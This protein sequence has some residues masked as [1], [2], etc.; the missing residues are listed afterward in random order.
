MKT[1]FRTLLLA[2]TVFFTGCIQMLAVRAVGG[3][4]EEGMDT[5]YEESDLDLAREG[6]SGNLKLLEALI[7]ADPE[8]E[9]LLL[10]AAQGFSAYSLAFAEDDSLERAQALYLRSRNYALRAFKERTGMDLMQLSLDEI[11]S[12]VPELSTDDLPFIF[13]TGFSWGSYINVNRDNLSAMAD[14]SK[15]DALMKYVLER[16]RDFYYGGADLYFGA[17][18]ASIPVMLGG[19]PEQ[20]R[21]HF[22][23]AIETSDGKFLMAYVIF[24]QTY[25]LQTL[26]EE[27]FDE[28]LQKVTDASLEDAPGIRLP[29]AV[30]KKKAHRLMTM[31][32]ELF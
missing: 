32:E 31:K 23:R 2:A 5:F 19:K 4:L 7:K 27:L 30:A 10:F 8:N 18:K 12:A 9:D 22:E 21:E 25:C 1:A 15:V 29:N 13:W 11:Q 26:N 24:A 28:L 14:I 3:I 16:D 6:L 20:A 17:M